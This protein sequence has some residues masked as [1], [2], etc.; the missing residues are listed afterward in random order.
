MEIPVYV[1]NARPIEAIQLVLSHD[2]RYVRIQSEPG[3]ISYVGTYFEQFLGKAFPTE[4]G[5]FTYGEPFT[6]TSSYQEDGFFTLSIVPD[7]L[8]RGNFSVPT[9]GETLVAKIR[10]E[11]SPDAPPGTLVR[12]DPADGPLGEGYGS[13]HLR[14]ELTYE[15]TGRYP[16]I[17]PRTLGGI[18]RIGVDGDISFFVRGDANGDGKVD[19]SDPVYTLAFL[20]LGAEDPAC[21]DAMDAD[22]DG[23]IIITD[24]IAVLSGLFLGTD[25]ISAP[26]PSS[27]RDE[28]PDFLAP[29]QARS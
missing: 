10:A 14:N 2:T 6:F 13:F 24:A 26:Y 20:F 1:S 18:L 28:H 16:T 23:S 22:D 8:G 3:V 11:V 21:P 27:G 12:L 5:F 17:A 9:E 29:C 25:S 4:G 15:G 19:I 7:I